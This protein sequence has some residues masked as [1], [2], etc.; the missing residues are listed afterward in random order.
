MIICW[1]TM[2]STAQHTGMESHKH[3]IGT[4]IKHQTM[5]TTALQMH[6]QEVMLETNMPTTPFAC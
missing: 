1:R 5:S 6:V 2:R 4:N 3:D